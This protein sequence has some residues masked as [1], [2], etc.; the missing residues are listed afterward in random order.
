MW[1]T[2][3]DHPFK[4]GNL[5]TKIKRRKN[6]C[7]CENGADVRKWG[8]D[9]K[10]ANWEFM[11]FNPGLFR[12]GRRCSSVQ[13]LNIHNENEKEEFRRSN[14]TLGD[15]KPP[16]NGKLKVPPKET[17]GRTFPNV[18]AIDS[19]VFSSEESKFLL[20]LYRK[21]H[22]RA[23]DYIRRNFSERNL[24]SLSGEK[25]DL[26]SSQKYKSECDLSTGPAKIRRSSFFH[27]S[28]NAI[29]KRGSLR[30]QDEDEINESSRNSKLDSAQDPEKKN[31]I[32]DSKPEVKTKGG[33]RNKRK[34][35]EKKNGG[36]G[37]QNNKLVN[38]KKKQSV[39]DCPEKS[40]VSRMFGGNSFSKLEPVSERNCKTK[41][42]NFNLITFPG[43]NFQE[44]LF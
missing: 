5:K 22:L 38:S 18:Q 15:L 7:E 11:N 2:T 41:G 13:N 8:G 29:K 25:S 28:N 26:K 43:K 42:K 1:F 12:Y 14:S 30:E 6:D 23:S 24:T 20:D 44:N 39:D 10:K 17:R 3:P 27:R 36:G 37:N 31:E 40:R 34:K 9:G 32:K 16:E 33:K 4:I 21:N 35:E 19:T